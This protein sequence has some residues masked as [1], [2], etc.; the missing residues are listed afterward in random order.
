MGNTIGEF[1]IIYNTKKIEVNLDLF[2]L[3]FNFLTIH[4]KLKLLECIVKNNDQLTNYLNTNY[5]NLKELADVKYNYNLLAV[6][7]TINLL[8]F[9]IKDAYL[10]SKSICNESYYISK[11]I[12]NEAAL[13][14]HLIVLELAHANGFKCDEWTCAYAANGGHL[15]VLKWLRE[16]KCP[17]NELTC[18]YAAEGGHLKVLQWAR[19]NGCPWDVTTCSIAAEKGHL[20]VLQWARTNG[21]EWD[22]WTCLN[23]YFN[24]HVEVLKWAKEH[25]CPCDVGI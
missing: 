22:E 2:R 15:D 23:A 16:N 10:S 6:N 20:K 5:F 12:C 11:S 25:G 7:G 17:W 9:R 13:N 3:I 8:R 24:F 14:G 18:A 1:T 19:D 21:C 4:D